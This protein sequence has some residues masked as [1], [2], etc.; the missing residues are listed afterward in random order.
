MIKPPRSWRRSI[1]LAASI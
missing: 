1:Q